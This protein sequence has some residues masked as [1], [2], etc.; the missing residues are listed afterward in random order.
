MRYV[1]SAPPSDLAEVVQ[2]TWTVEGLPGDSIRV[3]PDACTDLIFPAGGLL[4]FNGPMTVAEV[5]T[6]H[7]ELTTGV[8]FR[9]GTRV[10][11]AGVL[12]LR[13]M[14]DSDLV[15]GDGR[16]WAS[17]S[18]DHLLGFVRELQGRH[19]T[20]RNA[21]VD[22]VLAA[23]DA[24]VGTGCV[25]GDIY[26]ALGVRERQVERLFDL[27]VGLTPRQTLRVLRAESC[28]A[29]SARGFGRPGRTGGRSR[30]LRSAAPD[31][32]IPGSGRADARQ[33][34]PRD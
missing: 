30:L 33:I 24:S 10:L 26:G 23:I 12:R 13:E 7:T 17:A 29:L 25:L 27:F 20:E 32:G 18:G 22:A 3:T 1:E 16:G 28:H 34:P 11:V 19:A 31:Q 14:R 6:L 5:V 15:V 8:R 9:P 21:V 2:A 4:L